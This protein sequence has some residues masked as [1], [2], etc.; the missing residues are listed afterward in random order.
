MIVVVGVLVGEFAIFSQSRS[1]RSTSDWWTPQ[2]PASI[3]ANA[4]SGDHRHGTDCVRRSSTEW[5]LVGD[6]LLMALA[7]TTGAIGSA[8]LVA[9]NATFATPVTG[10]LFT[11]DPGDLRSSASSDWWCS[12][13]Q[14]FRPQTRSLPGDTNVRRTGV[15]ST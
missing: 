8:G 5:Y 4:G 1:G 11:N 9:F 2:S 15:W 12:S 14:P 3:G 7:Y 6:P 10:V 13:A